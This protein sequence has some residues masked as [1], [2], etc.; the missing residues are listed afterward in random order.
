MRKSIAENYYLECNEVMTDE[1]GNSEHHD[2]AKLGAE[3]V[4]AGQEYRPRQ[5]RATLD[6]CNVKVMI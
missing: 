1:I 3:V 4:A 2:A 5:K 6:K